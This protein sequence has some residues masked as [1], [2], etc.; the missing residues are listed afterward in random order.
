[1]TIF[2]DN[3]INLHELNL[4]FDRLEVPFENRRELI[5][6]ADSTIHHEIFDLIMIELPKT[7]HAIFL[8]YFSDDPSSL[9]ILGWLR[10]HIP[11]VEEKIR[12]RGSQIKED[13]KNEMRKSNESY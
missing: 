13:F 6:L 12:I 4:E 9:E 2:Y 3:L 7:H 10:G 11:D 1:M 8:K 5:D